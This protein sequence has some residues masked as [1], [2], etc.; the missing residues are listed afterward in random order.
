MFT[1]FS[2]FP[3]T[4]YQVPESKD[5]GSELGEDTCVLGAFLKNEKIFSHIPPSSGICH[6]I[7]PDHAN[8]WNNCDVFS[9][10]SRKGLLSIEYI[11]SLFSS[12][13]SLP[14]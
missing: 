9:F 12:S 8:A 11:H 7:V 14:L 6:Q 13:T 4:H 2:I 3:L 1:P 10:Y 5:T